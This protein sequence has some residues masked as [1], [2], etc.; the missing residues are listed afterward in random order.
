MYT[1]R[2]ATAVSCIDGRV[3]MPVIRYLRNRFAVDYVDVISEPGPDLILAYPSDKHTVE[4]ILRKV[5]MS[6]TRH[7][8]TIIAVVGHHDCS[9]N[10]APKEEQEEH[11]RLALTRLKSVFLNDVR[12][13][14][15]WVNKRWTVQEVP[16]EPKSILPLVRS[17]VPA[18]IA[19]GRGTRV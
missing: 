9:G 6:L 19:R 12:F 14:G 5:Q 15:L 18:R 10:P 7:A 13:I 17:K 4:A 2:F 11:I 8:S 16:L 1:P 3:Q